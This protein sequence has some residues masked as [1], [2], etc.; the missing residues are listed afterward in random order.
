MPHKKRYEEIIADAGYESLDNYLYLEQTVRSVSLKPPTMRRRKQRRTDLKS[1]ELRICNMTRIG[2][3][4]SAQREEN[5]T[6]EN[7]PHR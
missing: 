7:Y 4:L 6:A 3:P 1:V 2:T 5:C